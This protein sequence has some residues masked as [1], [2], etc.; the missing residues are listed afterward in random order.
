MQTAELFGKIM[1]SNLFRING[2][3]INLCKSINDLCKSILDEDE[4]NWEEGEF[5]ECCLSDF[6]VGA[7]W[8]F[9]ECHQG[10]SSESYGTL[11]R[12]G[13]IFSP[14]MGCGPDSPGETSAYEQIIEALGCTID[15]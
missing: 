10:Q 2:D 1:E 7:F 15:D 11:C 5:L 3:E 8:A 6:I 4:T 14:G 9:T 12:L 13:D